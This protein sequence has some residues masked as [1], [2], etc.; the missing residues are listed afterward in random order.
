MKDTKTSTQL[1][2]LFSDHHIVI[3]PK[4]S[5]ANNRFGRLLQDIE[6]WNIDC[7][8]GEVPE[9]S[10]ETSSAIYFP[11]RWDNKE[12]YSDPMNDQQTLNNIQERF[13]GIQKDGKE[14]TELDH[15]K[16]ELETKSEVELFMLIEGF[17]GAMHTQARGFRRGD[18]EISEEAFNEMQT[19]ML[20]K[21]HACLPFL[22]PFGLEISAEI[23][24]VDEAKNSQYR[25][26]YK[27]WRGWMENFSDEQW[28]VVESSLITGKFNKGLL[29]KKRWDE[30]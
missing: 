9:L 21:Q 5:D 12:L 14:Y 24:K 7:S 27:H 28:K 6:G 18:I 10:D 8:C 13:A 20:A 16:K 25:K 3:L 2:D 30:M 26:W 15:F 29:P 17:G 4:T 23:I 1:K 22:E 11:K 19:N